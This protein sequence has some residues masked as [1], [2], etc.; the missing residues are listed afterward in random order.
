MTCQFNTGDID[1]AI[2]TTLMPNSDHFDQKVETSLRRDIPIVT[3]PHARVQLTNQEHES[4]TNVSALAPFETGLVEIGGTGGPKRPLL[5]ITGLPG[6]H[7]PSTAVAGLLNKMANAVSI[8]LLPEPPEE[9][10]YNINSVDDNVIPLP[11]ASIDSP[12]DRLDPGTRHQR[13][14]PRSHRVHPGLPHLYHGRH[15]HDG[16]PRHYPRTLHGSR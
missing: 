15:P 9:S 8:S 10:N 3:S 16:S 2:K 1:T 13:R 11:S 12:H 4:F 5:R 6:K 7:V 14:Y